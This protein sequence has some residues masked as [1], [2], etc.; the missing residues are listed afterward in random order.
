MIYL[1]TKAAEARAC[2][3][4]TGF[5]ISHALPAWVDLKF[6]RFASS[7]S[8]RPGLCSAST[9]I[10][11]FGAFLETFHSGDFRCAFSLGTGGPIRNKLFADINKSSTIYRVV[12]KKRYVSMEIQQ[13]VVHH[14]LS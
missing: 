14:K 9:C 11:R 1:V 6:H 8:K 5:Y 3:A 4:W 10:A 2:S 13:A 7:F 12:S